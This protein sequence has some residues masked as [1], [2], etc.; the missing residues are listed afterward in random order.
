VRWSGWSSGSSGGCVVP[1]APGAANPKGAIADRCRLESA[2]ERRRGTPAWPWF[3]AHLLFILAASS[4]FIKHLFPVVF[5]LAIG[6]P[7]SRHVFWDLWPLAHVWLG[8]ALLAL[9]APWARVP[10]AI[11]ALALTAGI[12]DK[13]AGS[14]ARAS[15]AR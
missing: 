12:C 14:R 9:E 8:W 3:L 11:A 7:W 10:L 15:A 13:K 1:A 6:E 4:V 2:L 5:A